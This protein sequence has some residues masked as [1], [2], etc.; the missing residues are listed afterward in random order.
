MLDAPELPF[1]PAHCIERPWLALR[2]C[3]VPRTS[4]VDRQRSIREF[5]KTELLGR[6]GF[7]NYDPIGVFCDDQ[8]CRM[9]KDNRFLYR[10]SNH[11][12]IHGS[13]A[14]ADDLR[15]FIEAHAK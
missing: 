1:M 4:Y 3:T 13:R 15:H 5:V 9:R 10:D 6:Q 14:V 2:D 11:L 8:V 7:L 12:S